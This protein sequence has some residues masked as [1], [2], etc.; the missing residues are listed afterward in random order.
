MKPVIEPLIIDGLEVQVIRKKIKNTYLR[1]CHQT[2]QVRLSVPRLLPKAKIDTFIRSKRDWIDKHLEQISQK[3]KMVSY[4][5]ISGE[6]H[7]FQGHLYELE[8]HLNSLINE[9]QLD[10][11]SKRLVMKTK[12]ELST[13]QKAKLLKEWYRR[14]MKQQLPSLI[15]KWE[16]I[17]GVQS[18]DWGV[19]QM[20]SRWGTCNTQTKKIWLS[21]ELIKKPTICLEYVLVHELVHLLERKH[22][23]VFYAHMS[24]YM[25]DWKSYDKILKE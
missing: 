8:L 12:R 24:R 4:A 14:Q 18:S 16:K 13:D 3:P 22:N 5:Y 9:V 25:P 21:L 19:K 7:L 10:H 6:L 20:K 17:I 2:G 15:N 1:I 23:K 11:K